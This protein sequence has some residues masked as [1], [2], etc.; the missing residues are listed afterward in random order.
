M[1]SV[2][3]LLTLDR[4]DHNSARLWVDSSHDGRL[5]PGEEV[6]LGTRDGLHWAGRADLDPT[7]GTRF[8]LL[9]NAPV[10]TKWSFVAVEVGTGR[11]LYSLVNQTTAVAPEQLVGRLL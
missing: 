7:A 1:S 10:G 4:S 2:S 3:Y 9:F 8:L 11:D 5:D 6:P